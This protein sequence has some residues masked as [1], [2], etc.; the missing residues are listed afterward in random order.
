MIDSQIQQWVSLD[1]KQL[2]C[3]GLGFQSSTVFQDCL[4]MTELWVTRV[5]LNTGN[6]LQFGSI[7]MCPHQPVW[8]NGQTD[9]FLKVNS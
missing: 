5:D 1:V 6:T 8:M 9:W 3:M 2:V 7:S 4:G